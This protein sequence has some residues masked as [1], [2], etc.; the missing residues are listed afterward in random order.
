MERTK[1]AAAIVAHPDD[2][3]LWAGGAIR[4]HRDYDWTIVALCRRS[5]PDRAPRFSRAVSRL[6]TAGAMADL[7]DGPEQTPLDVKDLEDTILSLLPRKDFDLLVTHSPFGEYTRHRRHEET[8]RAVAGLWAQGRLTAGELWMFAYEDG[9]KSYFPRA[10]DRAHFKLALDEK[11]WKEKVDII[12]SVYGFGADSWEAGTTPRTE[13]FWRFQDIQAY[14]AW[15][16]N[17]K[18]P[19]RGDSK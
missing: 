5:D 7:D 6:G 10:I 17:E 15:Y 1:H 12:Q 9:G 3:T 2:E 18:N 19:S 14:R 13:A 16:A 4:R 11:D 8:A